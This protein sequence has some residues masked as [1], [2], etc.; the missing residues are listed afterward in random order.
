[1]DLYDRA[2]AIYERLVEQEG[3]KELLGDLA[4]VIA[5]RAKVFLDLGDQQKS[6]SD[7]RKAVFTLKAEIARTGRADLQG[8]LDWATK[9]LH[10]VL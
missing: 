8:V 1:V 5:Y 6:R 10:E 3:R 7:A 2:A 9:A 4:W